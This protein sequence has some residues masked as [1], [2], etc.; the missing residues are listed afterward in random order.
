M[1]FLRHA[2]YQLWSGIQIIAH[3]KKAGFYIVFFQRVQDRGGA[4]VF[5][6]AVKGQINC[7]FPIL[8]FRR[9][10]IGV[11]IRQIFRRGVACRR[12]ARLLKAQAPVGNGRRGLS[13]LFPKQR[14]DAEGGRQHS[15]QPKDHRTPGQFF[16]LI[17][18]NPSPLF[19][20]NFLM[21]S[22][23]TP[24][25][26]PFMLRRS[27]TDVILQ[28]IHQSARILC[29]TINKSRRPNGTAKTRQADFR[30]FA[31]RKSIQSMDLRK[32]EGFAEPYPFRQNGG[33]L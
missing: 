13:R 27:K 33:S 31:R 30:Q 32:I 12:F 16:Q 14:R 1:P 21:R 7:L 22:I 24:L 25:C 2:L 20:K 4:A 15:R 23:S 19:L 26:L 11:K 10:K 17:Q 5:I 18:H 9:H 8:L 3:H 28:K 29:Y 6:A